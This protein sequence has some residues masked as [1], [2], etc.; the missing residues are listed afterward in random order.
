[1]RLRNECLRL[2]VIGVGMV[3]LQSDGRTHVTR[4]LHGGTCAVDVWAAFG[5]SCI[6]SGIF[7][8]LMV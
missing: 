3:F 2:G 6:D 8:L 7:H 5:S 4:P 1:M